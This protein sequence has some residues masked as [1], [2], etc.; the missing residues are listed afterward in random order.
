MRTFQKIRRVHM[1]K[2]I[3]ILKLNFEILLKPKSDN[4]FSWQMYLRTIDMTQ[5]QWDKN[6]P[7]ALQNEQFRN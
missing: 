1:Q 4:H 2:K 5:I 6:V 3:R 7:A